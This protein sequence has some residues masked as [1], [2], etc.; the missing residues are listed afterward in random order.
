MKILLSIVLLVLNAFSLRAQSGCTDP[1]ALNYNPNA[2][3]NDGSC[4][5]AKT[6]ASPKSKATFNS[7]IKES[8]GLVFTD[9][10]LW[11]HNDSGNSPA[12]YSIDTATGI[13][14]QTIIIDNFTNTDWEDIDADN[15][16]IYIADCGNNDGTRKDLR[17]LKI[18]KSAIGS[19]ATVH[20][21]AQAIMFSYSDQTS[22]VKSDAHNFDCE[23][24]VSIDTSLY[25][26][27]KDRGDE[28]TRVYRLSKHPG[29]YSVTP[30]T[31]FDSKGLV[32][33]AA[34]NPATKQ[35]ALLGY[36]RN[37]TGSFLLLFNDFSGDLF[38]S[39]NKRRIEF[40]NN[41]EWQTEGITFQSDSVLYVS[42]EKGGDFQSSF[43]TLN[44]NSWKKLTEVEEHTATPYQ[45]LNIYPNPTHSDI[46]VE[47][48]ELINYITLENT[49]GQQIASF[50]VNDYSFH[51]K[52]DRFGL[53]EGIYVLKI[54]SRKAIKYQ[55]IFV[56]H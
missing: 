25:I 18:A 6:S 47:N 10:K 24:L 36:S 4:L 50:P 2:I 46:T 45:S 5:Y 29:T 9:G 23:S 49:I 13:T 43:Y 7:T 28:Q 48:S 38:F 37:K 55:P 51:G 35:I 14:L 19:A 44:M 26:F 17:I 31:S 34:Y 21:N 22:F 3:T 15:D 54:Q 52:L 11:T 30:Y 39:G 12:I 27:T 8:S 16:F 41:K 1:E 56:V 33:G 20:V 40:D 53:S 42:C 32:T